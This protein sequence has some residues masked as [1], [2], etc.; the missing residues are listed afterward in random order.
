MQPPAIRTFP[1]GTHAIDA[2]YIRPGVAASHLI[3]RDGRAAVVDSGTNAC[4]PALLAALEALG[5][6][7]DA[8]DYVVLTHVH[9]DHAGGAGALLQALPE[10]VAVLHPR[11]VPN[12]ADPA[13]LEAGA[14]AVYG[15]RAYDAL[16]GPLIPIA[17]ARL[18]G[19][20]DDEVLPLGSSRL[21]TLE[22]PG[23]ALHHLA[24]Y[25]ET[26]KAV[27][28]GDI[29]G[30]SYR[31]F[32]NPAGEAFIFPTT[33]PT[34]FDPE[35]ANASIERIRALAP[36]AV[37]LTHFSRVTGIARLADDLHRDLDRF[38]AIAAAQAAGPDAETRTYGALRD[39]L[40]GR[41]AAHGTRVDAETRDTWLEMDVRL[42]AAGLL[43]W[44][45][46]LARA[47]ERTP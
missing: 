2:G 8:V 47:R 29:F 39:H 7:R 20:E 44:Q 12:L 33:A 41:L 15:D 17:E 4:V 31:V 45:R 37:Y 10:A 27:F 18:R 30:I 25:D 24:V 6:G 36:Q 40:I 28:S 23:H 32:D 16:Y 34:Q 14:R 38:V 13:K 26:A 11:A 35:Q 42:N 21:R 19:V 5:V 22:T 1:H 43:A 3:V 46:R 9:L